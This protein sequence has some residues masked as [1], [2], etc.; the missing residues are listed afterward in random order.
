M[1]KQ[2]PHSSMD[3]ST[4]LIDEIR[5]MQRSI[6]EVA[7]KVNVMYAVHEQLKRQSD[8]IKKQRMNKIVATT[9]GDEEEDDVSSGC[10]KTDSNDVTSTS[11]DGYTDD[12]YPTS[13]PGVS[14]R[15]NR[16]EAESRYTN[17]RGT[18]KPCSCLSGCLYSLC[19]CWLCCNQK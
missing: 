3:T 19:C 14:V 10:D 4:V 1:D 12:G 15:I 11:V 16:L 13:N 5:K 9:S 7:T 17:K 8:Y 18:R 2:Q 6:D